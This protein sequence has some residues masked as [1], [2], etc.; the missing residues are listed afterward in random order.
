MG[1]AKTPKSGL[2]GSIG[3]A[4]I[5]N[6]FHVWA[7]P[8]VRKKGHSS[9]K[10]KGQAVRREVRNARGIKRGSEKSR[11]GVKKQVQVS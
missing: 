2:V 3:L 11:K 10:I 7:A 6:P 5:W 4:Q 8:G 1:T 9:R